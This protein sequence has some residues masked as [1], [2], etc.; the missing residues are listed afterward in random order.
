[1]DGNKIRGSFY[2]NSSDPIP[3]NASPLEVEAALSGV[4]G[5]RRVEVAK[6]QPDGKAGYTWLVT[7][8]DV[9]G[10]VNNL[11]ASN[12]LTGKGATISVTELIKGNELR[13]S[14]KL[15]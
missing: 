5:I 7:F 14:F 3:Y 9:S 10:D 1:M 12:S 13:G 15:C 2:L 6:L 8:L 4:S 11:H